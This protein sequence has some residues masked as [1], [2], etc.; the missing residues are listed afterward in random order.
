MKIAILGT[1]GVP[2]YHGGFE[3]FAEFFSVYMASNGYDIYVYNSHNHPYKQSDFKGVKIVHCFDPEYKLGTAGQFLY[4][5]NCIRDIRKRNFDIILQLGYTSSSIWSWLFPKKVIIVTNMD[6]LEWKRSKYSPTVQKFL[7]KAEKWAVKYSDFHIAD[8][9]GIQ[10]YLK[11]K[12]KI[13]SKFIAYGAFV[14]DNP[15]EHKIL[16][17]NVTSYNYNMLIARLE[18]ENNIETIL[19]GYVLS[20]KNMPF[21]VVGKHE[22]KFGEYLK[23]KY[24]EE[25]GIRFLGGIYDFNML[26]NLRYF[27]NLYFHGHSVGGTNPSLL[28]AMASNTLIVA[29]RNIFNESI[30]GNDAYYFES[31]IDVKESLE[32]FKKDNKKKIINNEKKINEKYNWDIINNVYREFL[33]KISEN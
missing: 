9:I 8:S 25:V 30:L 2:N 22:T 29:N 12:Y 11:E 13:E 28:E 31:A 15:K 10:E 24:K 6:G 27:S 5:L 17:Y 14:F 4:D 21:L 26:N 20:S 1:R 32:Y 7:L 33:D 3:Q 16:K 19:D 23:D 18:P